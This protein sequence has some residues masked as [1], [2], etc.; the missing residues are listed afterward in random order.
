MNSGKAKNE[1]AV[2][3]IKEA[4]KK[5]YEKNPCGYM[6]RTEVPAFFG[7]YSTGTLANLDCK[8]KGIKGAFRIGR[9]IVYPLDSLA[10]FFISRLEV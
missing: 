2:N 1:T 3:A 9:Q 4:V 6:K 5:A 10:E 7:I 8:H